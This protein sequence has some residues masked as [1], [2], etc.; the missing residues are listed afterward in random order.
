MLCRC[1]QRAQGPEPAILT[2]SADL[3]WTSLLSTGPTSWWRARTW[4]GS[5]ARSNPRPPSSTTPHGSSAPR[6]R[7]RARISVFHFEPAT[8]WGARIAR[9]C[10]AARC[11]SR[12]LWLCG[13][14]PD[15]V[16][17]VRPRHLVVIWPSHRAS[18]IPPSSCCAGHYPSWTKQRSGP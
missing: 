7:G 15:C 9:R 5:G 11:D 14:R 13:A 2:P 3:D 1:L 12:N 4:P 17:I 8:R 6:V 10:D 16:C 18:T